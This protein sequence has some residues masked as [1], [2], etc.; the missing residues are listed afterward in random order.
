MEGLLN[1]LLLVAALVCFLKGQLNA[2]GVA[3]RLLTLAR[4]RSFDGHSKRPQSWA[5][6]GGIRRTGGARKGAGHLRFPQGSTRV[7][8][9]RND[10]V[11]VISKRHTCQLRHY[12]NIFYFD[13]NIV[14]S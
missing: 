6:V 5:G 10:H 9:S 7:H 12:E 1:K 4:R 8:A 11:E 2:T 14:I 13:D 3:C